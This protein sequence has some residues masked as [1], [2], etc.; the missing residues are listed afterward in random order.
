MTY[1]VEITVQPAGLAAPDLHR[2]RWLAGRVL[3]EEGAAPCEVGVV[4][5]DDA[6]IQALNRHYR[7]WDAP[8]DVLAF[9]LAE[10]EQPFPR[11]ARGRPYLGDVTISLERAEEQAAEQ[12]HSLQREVELLLVHGLLHLLGYDDAREPARRKML[13]RQE[14]LWLKFSPGR[15]SLV[16]SFRAAF[17]GLGNLIRTQRNA[18]IHLALAALAVLLGVLLRLN[19]TEWVLLALTMAFVLVTEALNSAME[20]VMDIASPET[21]PLARRGKDLAAAAVLLAALLALV[22]G[23][24]LFVPRLW[25]WLP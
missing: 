18:R 13:A 5:T 15:S 19:R 17:A 23:G 6:G 9:A 4:L 24:V 16:V 8:T 10:G 2:L 25:E 1:R 12:G 7:D 21:R 14:R 3:A 11:P 22:V 20:A